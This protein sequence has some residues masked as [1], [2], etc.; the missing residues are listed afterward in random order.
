MTP[1]QSSNL[2]G[3]DYDPATRTLTIAFNSGSTYAY[4]GVSED[5]YDG[6]RTSPSPGSYFQRQI[7]DRYPTEKI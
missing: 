3:C 2:S 5:V 7:K 4:A 6:L 1:L